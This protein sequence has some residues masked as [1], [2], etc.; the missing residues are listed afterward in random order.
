VRTSFLQHLGD[1]LG[2][3]APELG[4]L[5]LQSFDDGKLIRHVA[6]IVRAG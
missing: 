1:V 4:Q 5:I 2:E 6:R 3:L